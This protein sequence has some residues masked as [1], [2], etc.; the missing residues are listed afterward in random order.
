M[1]PPA[2]CAREHKYVVLSVALLLS[3]V[4]IVPPLCSARLSHQTIYSS[5]RTLLLVSCQRTFCSLPKMP[6]STGTKSG[7]SASVRVTASSVSHNSTRA[8][9]VFPSGQGY[10]PAA[11]QNWSQGV[12][13]G[14]RKRS[15][16]QD[17]AVQ[18]YL[19]AK[20]ALFSKSG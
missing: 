16:P 15:D 13:D 7:S 4:G 2:I 5:N 12:S 8:T 14:T 18:A 6:H 11:I 20:M 3:N 1:F 9:P 17:P 10:N 19:Q